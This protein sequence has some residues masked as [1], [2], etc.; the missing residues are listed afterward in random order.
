MRGQGRT[1]RAPPRSQGLR[2]DDCKWVVPEHGRNGEAPLRTL[3]NPKVNESR[4]QGA[5][6]LQGAVLLLRLL[7]LRLLVQL[8]QLVVLAAV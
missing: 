5:H 3:A 4:V 6:C 2:R 1:V 8:V 7:R